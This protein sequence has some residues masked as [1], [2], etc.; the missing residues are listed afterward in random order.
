MPPHILLT[1][2][3]E[4]WFQV[5]NFKEFIPYS[6]WPSRELRVEKNT[7]RLL[8]L[9]DKASHQP[10]AISYQL[11]K[12]RVTDNGEPKKVCATFFVLGWLAER[13]PHLVREIHARGHEV[14]SHGY[15]H[16]LCSGQSQRDRRT[17]ATAKSCWRISSVNRFTGTVPPVF[18]SVRRP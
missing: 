16:E 6:S 2:D 5:E 13:L 12:E 1:I 17:F 14:A 7:Q 4:D 18:R 10:S 9:L 11:D 8:D 15:Q 3:V